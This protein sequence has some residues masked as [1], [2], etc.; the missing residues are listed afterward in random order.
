MFAVDGVRERSPT[1]D[2]PE[3]AAQWKADFLDGKLR[4]PGDA[5][6]LT[7]G[8]A[9]QL[10][11]EDIEATGARDGT[12]S[13]YCDHARTL[14]AHFG[15][16]AA[17]LHL[18]AKGDIE[19]FVRKRRAA[20]V[21]ASTIVKKELQVLKRMLRLARDAGYQLPVDPFAK[22]RL[23][24]VRTGRFDFLT[25]ERVEDLVAAMR[26]HRARLAGWHADIVEILFATGLRRAELFR[27]TVRDIDFEAGRIFVDGKV[28]PRYQTF[29]KA[30]EPVLRRLVA[31]AG[32]GG[33]IVAR[34]DGLEQA[35]QTWQRRLGEPRMTPH[36]LR[37]SFGS[38]MASRV[39]PFDLMGLMGHSSL[40][41]T[42]RYFHARGDAVRDALDSLRLDRPDPGPSASGPKPAPQSEGPPDSR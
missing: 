40:T 1:Y 22:L 20:G 10:I 31:A 6:E 11:L 24:T 38:A 36:V 41:Q 5:L 19:A 12:R 29:G 28:R 42:S 9:L 27:L 14:F 21:T 18:I 33:A 32:K 30:L 8:G 16:K 35:F 13:F 7:L 37:H 3:A 39:G 25:Q 2:T 26:K 15:G 23:P 17:K 34:P 4:P